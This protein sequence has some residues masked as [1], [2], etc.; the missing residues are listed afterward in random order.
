DQRAAVEGEVAGRER[1]DRAADDVRDDD[2][3]RVDRVAVALAGEVVGARREGEQRGVAGEVRGRARGRLGEPAPVTGGEAGAR[4]TEGEN[5]IGVHARDGTSSAAAPALTRGR[6]TP[7]RSGRR[8][9]GGPRTSPRRRA[10]TGRSPRGP[11]SRPGPRRE[12]GSRRPC[13]GCAAPT[14]RSAPRRTA[15]SATPCARA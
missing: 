1:V 14:R 12:R 11:R 15:P 7:A 9:T 3:A 4:E 2:V 13:A 10:R 8:G 5:L 6:R